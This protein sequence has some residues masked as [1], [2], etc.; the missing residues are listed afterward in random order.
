MLKFKHQKRWHYKI[1]F[2]SNF[3]YRKERF[4]EALVAHKINA[5]LHTCFAIQSPYAKEDEAAIHTILEKR[6]LRYKH[7]IPKTISG[8]TEI[9][10]F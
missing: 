5:K 3:E 2:A 9:Y 1:G 7:N 8:W 6:K 10:L 4:K